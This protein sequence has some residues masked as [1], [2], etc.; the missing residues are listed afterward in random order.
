LPYLK[1]IN[2]NPQLVTV[3]SNAG[4]APDGNRSPAKLGLRFKNKAA[5]KR[6]TARLLRA[7]IIANCFGNTGEIREPKMENKQEA[8]RF[9]RKTS[10]IL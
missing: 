9:W 6:Y 8:L 7:G 3:F 2:R 5:C 10:M 1:K 4:F